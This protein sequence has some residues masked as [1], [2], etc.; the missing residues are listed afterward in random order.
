M[1]LSIN[2]PI[3][4]EAMNDELLVKY[5]LNEATDE[6]AAGVRSWIGEQP[7]NA[8]YFQ[9]FKTIWEE[10]RKLAAVS[11]VDVD[12]AWN[13]FQGLV[14]KEKTQRKTVSFLSKQI[15]RIA[16]G[17]FLLVT[18]SLVL[19]YLNRTPEWIV[20]KCDQVPVTDTLPD[21]SVVTLNKHSELRYPQKFK[22]GTRSVALN[23]EAFFE[24]A[25]DKS[26][27]FIITAN[28]ASV[29][30]VGTSFNVKSSPSATEVIVATGV[31]EVSRNQKA[32]RLLPNET[33]T[34]Y[35][36][37][38]EFNKRRTEDELY[39]YYRTKEFVCNNTPLSRMAEVLSEAYNVRIEIAD[40]ALRTIPL[41]VTFQNESLPEVL[42]VICETLNI[43][44]IQ[45]NDRI[46]FK[47]R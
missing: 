4:D 22:G 1:A 27:P 25:P 8:R 41:T 36:G 7:Q 32:V 34:V 46:I 11:T 3:P 15:M 30:V 23:G 10:S 19:F 28:E 13:R 43:Q 39:N 6:E 31:V 24:V 40:P 16:A 20:L 47:S 33:T 12:V 26:H 42:R 35:K 37:K 17:L 21:G 18:G 44:A 9:D 38:A 45:Q 2:D 14:A 29:K 5:L